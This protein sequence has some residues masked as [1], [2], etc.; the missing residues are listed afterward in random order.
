M[1]HGTWEHRWRN[2]AAL[3]A[4]S[5]VA[6]TMMF[7]HVEPAGAGGAPSGATS[8]ALSAKEIST[9]G[10]SLI[11]NVYQT[12]VIGLLNG[13]ARDMNWATSETVFDQTLFVPPGS[14]EVQNALEA[15]RVA[16][17]TRAQSLANGMGLVL[18]TFQSTVT[19]VAN[20]TSTQASSVTHNATYLVNASAT[21]HKKPCTRFLWICV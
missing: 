2:V 4:L 9:A 20:S 21:Y 7:A 10:D 18:E 11:T 19:L 3:A 17:Q 16:A 8:T 13:K 14:A 5:V 6:L 1:A 15:A 12:H